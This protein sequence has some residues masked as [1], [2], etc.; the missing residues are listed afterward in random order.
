M[1]RDFFSNSAIYRVLL[2]F[3][4]VGAAGATVLGA[5]YEV[6]PGRAYDSIGDVP[7]ESLQAGDTVLIHW[8]STP[9][10]EKWVICRQGT[11][12]SPI[13]IRGI[14]GPGGELPV[15]D[16]NGATTR[17]ALNFW[18]EVRG[19]LKIGGA[20]IPPDTMP[21]H[22]V[23]ENLHIRSGRPPYTFSDDGGS[24]RTY[25]NNAAALYIEKGENIT[26][27]NCILQDCG[28][29]I[30]VSSSTSQASRDILVEGSYIHS[31]GIEDSIY[32]HNNYTAAIGIIFQHNRFGPLRPGCL[33]NNLK[34]RSA[35]LM[36]RYNWIEGG[37][38]QLDLVDGEDSGLIRSHPSYRETHVYGNVLI[39]PEAAGNRQM[40][41]Y[42]GDSGNSGA[43]RKGTMYFYHNTLV[44]TRSDRTTLMRLSTNDEHCDF[45]NNI[46]FVT[47]GGGTLSL[48]DSSGI[49]DLSHNWIKPGWV[50]TFGSLGGVINDDGTSVQGE[51]PGFEDPAGKIFT[52]TGGSDCIDAGTDLHPAVLSDADV[53]RHYVKHRGD[54]ARPTDGSLDIGAYEY[55]AATPS[56]CDIS[57][58]GSVNVIDLQLLINVILGIDTAHM[59]DLN[60]DGR[61][62]VL[63]LQTL[64]NVILGVMACPG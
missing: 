57:Q 54:E 19:V 12:S 3:L 4:I 38:R 13:R 49:L 58:D 30:F 25:A 11:A 62:D 23:V 24:V 64:A 5:T 34:D 10:R 63:D 1:F 40:V 50:A 32:H 44:S 45:R 51:N 27:R 15:I 9:Y 46:L 53:A 42:G 52:L 60:G 17:P 18:N 55:S 37:N 20:G 59:G 22:I 43:Y 35:G 8:Q 33:G 36:V 21:K 61:T 56:P 26:I 2:L 39:E 14:P 6:G 28:N 31:N 29:G 41:H 16:G 48:L 7:W 47:A